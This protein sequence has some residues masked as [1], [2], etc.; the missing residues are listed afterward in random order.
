MSRCRRAGATRVLRR[1][2]AYSP[3]SATG[4]SKAALFSMAGCPYSPAAAKAPARTT[5]LAR[6]TTE[7]VARNASSAAMRRDR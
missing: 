2:P 3:A 4:S 5:P 6:M 1:D 7:I